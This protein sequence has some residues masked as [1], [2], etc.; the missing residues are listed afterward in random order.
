ME[1]Y[2]VDALGYLILGGGALVVAFLATVFLASDRSRV[3]L[4]LLATPLV[5]LGW[6]I[7]LKLTGAFEVDSSGQCTDCG[8][9]A[10][11]AMLAV[12]GNTIGWAV[13]VVLGAVLRFLAAPL[14]WPRGGRAPRAGSTAYRPR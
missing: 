7:P 4:L 13:G 10:L 9:G 5:A 6:W 8:T 3:V 1:W 11:V 12:L 14:P 2:G